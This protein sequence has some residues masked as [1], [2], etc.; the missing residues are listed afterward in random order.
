MGKFFSVDSGFYKFMS[1]L[2][3]ML[4]LNGMWLLCSL[5]IF[6]I[7]A[8]TTA[9]YSITLKMVDDEEGYIA[10]PFLRA[11]KENLGKGSIIGIIQ[12]FATYT[13]IMDFQISRADSKFGT[14]YFVV[15][16]ICSVLLLTH[17]LYA[18]ALLARYENSVINTMRNSHSIFVKYFF[19]SVFLIIVILVEMFVFYFLGLSEPTL[20]F[21]GII[22][23]PA[24]IIY[25]ISGFARQFFRNIEREN[26]LREEE[27]KAELAEE[28]QKNTEEESEE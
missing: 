4:K 2:F 13:I 9:A 20:M 19:K 14:L 12:V 24:C 25:T 18:Y 3:D 17:T 11:F 23:G 22:L 27:I 10:G 16:V 15:G 28:K 1:R 6:T 7:G 8:A 5:P 21:F 26:E